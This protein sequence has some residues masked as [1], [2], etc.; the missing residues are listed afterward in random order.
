MTARPP[1]IAR[2]YSSTATVALRF[3][4]L[5]KISARV[6]ETLMSSFVFFRCLK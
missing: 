2:Q 5:N 4:F 3:H 1:V 6:S